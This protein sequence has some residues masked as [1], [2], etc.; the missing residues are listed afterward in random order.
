MH[1]SY[2]KTRRVFGPDRT[3]NRRWKATL[4]LHFTLFAYRSVILINKPYTK[5]RRYFETHA[6]FLWPFVSF[7]TNVTRVRH[8]LIC[9]CTYGVA[10][11][12]E[13]PAN[14]GGTKNVIHSSRSEV[15]T[16]NSTGGDWPPDQIEPKAISQCTIKHF[17]VYEVFKQLERRVKNIEYQGNKHL[18][19]P[20]KLGILRIIL[21]LVTLLVMYSYAPRIAVYY[22]PLNML[23]IKYINALIN[24]TTLFYDMYLPWIRTPPVMS[25]TCLYRV[26]EGLELWYTESDPD[27]GVFV[28]S[29]FMQSSLPG[30]V[31]YIF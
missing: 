23:I 4:L 8:K 17:S 7:C 24:I 9:A 28:I 14:T 13:A 3:G 30:A 12:A 2:F 25:E 18:H 29:S 6:I 20:S 26:S 15:N 31:R 27:G 10:T 11:R 19:T 1:S 21:F 5:S 16:K 22:L